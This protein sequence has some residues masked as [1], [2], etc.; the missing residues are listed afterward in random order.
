MYSGVKPYMNRETRLADLKKGQTA[1]VSGLSAEGPMRRRLQD[2][3]LIL[4]TQVECV[5][6]SPLGDPAAY[7]IRGAVVALRGRDAACI[8]VKDAS[9]LQQ[10]KKSAL[11]GAVHPSRTERPLGT[12][13][14]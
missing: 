12:V 6:V 2:I 3:G 14:E 9:P 13:G 8:S 7:L 4:G 11:P 1:T 10:P 5:S